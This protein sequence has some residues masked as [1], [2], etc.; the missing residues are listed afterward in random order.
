[1]DDIQPLRNFLKEI[2]GQPDMIYTR[3]AVNHYNDLKE[4]VL[5]QES[6]PGKA[7]RQRHLA[8]QI[9]SLQEQIL[10][11]EREIGDAIQYLGAVTEAEKKHL[12]NAYHKIQ[13]QEQEVR[14]LLAQTGGL[15]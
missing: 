8:A 13:H 7:A 14:R 12:K 2:Q 15:S 1:M 4:K 3:Q 10:V 5:T 6:D 11:Y 9:E